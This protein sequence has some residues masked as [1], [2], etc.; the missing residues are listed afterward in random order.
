M[1]RRRFLSSALAASG[2]LVP[3]WLLDQPKG[4]SMVSVPGD[5]FTAQWVNDPP[6]PGS[7]YWQAHDGSYV[8][9]ALAI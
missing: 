1:N 3:E 5:L 2:L 6:R 9:L 7:W 4:R 8:T